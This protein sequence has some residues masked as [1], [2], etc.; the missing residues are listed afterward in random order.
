MLCRSGELLEYNPRTDTSSG[1][2][3]PIGTTV[4]GSGDQRWIRTQKKHISRAEASLPQMEADCYCT[5]P[6]LISNS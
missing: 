2:S 5:V 4:M 6:I 3:V 1:D